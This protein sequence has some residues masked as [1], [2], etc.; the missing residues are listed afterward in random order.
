MRVALADDAVILREGL[1]RLLQQA[2]FNVV[3]TAADGDE[4]LDVEKH[5]KSIFAT[6]ALSP[7]P[8]DHRRVL[9]VL[10]YLHSH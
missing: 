2:G 3:G 7:S 4:L 8:D 10:T 1:A 9:A 5:V 6:L